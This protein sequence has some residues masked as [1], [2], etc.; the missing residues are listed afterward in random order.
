MNAQNNLHNCYSYGRNQL[1][2]GLNPNLPS[3]LVDD[4]SAIEETSIVLLRKH[5][6]VIYDSRKAFIESMSNKKL[7]R[8]I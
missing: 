7:L 8:E 2:L 6:N 5:L 4:L 3:F 1:F